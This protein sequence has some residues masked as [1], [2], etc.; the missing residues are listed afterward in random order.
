MGT[1]LITGA[2]SGLG[3]EF[4]WQLAAAKH[5]LVLVSRDTGRL[6]ELADQLRAAANVRVEVLPADLTEPEELEI[7]AQRLQTLERPVGLLINNAG[8]GIAQ[9][10]VGGDLDREVK[11]LDLMVKAMLVLSHTAAQQMSSRGRGAILNVGSVAGHLATGTYS[12]HK[13][14]VRSFT[15]SLA[16]E[17]RQTGVTATVLQPGFV[18]TE[19]HERAEIDSSILP[20]FAWLNA[21]D[22][23]SAALRD[24]RRGVVLSTPSL[25]YRAV[26]GLLRIAPRRTIRAFGHYDSAH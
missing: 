9:G 2:S 23:V 15:E 3:L 25:R 7:V 11:A 22:V 24:V 14:W 6:T 12:A 8:L 5:N 18:R 19:F 17:L 13:A 26:S 1:A 21:E 20:N 4:A 10:F 16:V